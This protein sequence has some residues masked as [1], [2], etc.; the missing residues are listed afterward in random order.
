MALARILTLLALTAVLPATAAA[1]TSSPP[2]ELGRC[3]QGDPSVQCHLW[4]G[5]VTFI[6][7]GDTVSVDLDGDD[8]K[9]PVRVR[10]TGINAPEQT[11]HTN[12]PEDRVGE[13]HAN[14]ATARLEE[15]VARG[16]GRVKLAAINP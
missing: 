11:V 5:N 16:G 12:V 9:Q 7:D 15:L 6:G 4:T 2:G 1:Q 13:C 3:P 14:E 8:T 10:M